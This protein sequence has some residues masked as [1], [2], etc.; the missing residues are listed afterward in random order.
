MSKKCLVWVGKKSQNP[1]AQVL[2]F[3]NLSV[4]VTGLE[5]VTTDL[6]QTYTVTITNNPT[7]VPAVLELDVPVDATFISASDGW[8]YNAWTRKVTRPSTN[9]NSWSNVDRTVTLT[10]QEEATYIIN[11][12]VATTSVQP[13]NANNSWSI[14]VDAEAPVSSIEIR[15]IQPEEAL[16]IAMYNFVISWVSYLS[17]FTFDPV[18]IWPSWWGF[19][20]RLW[21]LDWSVPAGT[22][23]AW[24]NGIWYDCGSF[25]EF[26]STGSTAYVKNNPTTVTTDY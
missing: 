12:D 24:W 10:F 26:F 23:W 3:G 4:E 2:G 7:I 17:S 5:N 13:V 16:P 1:N 21:D 15:V 11:S 9:I 22:I 6:N 14:S 18:Y 8:T 25:T 20:Y 19:L